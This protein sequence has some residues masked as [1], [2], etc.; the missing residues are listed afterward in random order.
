V[1]NLQ[2]NTCAIL[3]IKCVVSTGPIRIFYTHLPDAS[4]GCPGNR[5]ASKLAIRK[6]KLKMKPSM[7]RNSTGMATLCSL[8][9]A[10]PLQAATVVW[11]TP[12]AITDSSDV[13][14][15]GTTV[16]AVQAERSTAAPRTVNGVTFTPASATGG[17]ADPYTEGGVTFTTTTT[18]SGLGASMN[19]TDPFLGS[20]V[21]T[22]AD[23]TA[24]GQMLANSFE[25][26]GAA[27]GTITLTGL[28]D[29][30]QY[31]VQ[32]WVAD[33]RQYTN[34]R[35]ITIGSAGATGNTSSQLFFLGGNGSSPSSGRGNFITGTF[36]AVGTTQAFP[37]N[38]TGADS[39]AM[40]NA[41]QLRAI[42]EP[43]ATLLGGLGLLGLLRR[44]RA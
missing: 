30:N 11:A 8:A 6:M 5:F 12:T 42:P 20:K 31:L 16:L 34:N 9:L 41:F 13:N 29:G 23:G 18:A 39:V 17:L 1:A 2:V 21:L 14:I 3:G 4:L 40:I 22:G 36:T 7:N 27:G 15:T 43:A 37:I 33:F 44:R 25:V 19:A 26:N 38:M 24:Y 28:T 32:F 10:L 35:S